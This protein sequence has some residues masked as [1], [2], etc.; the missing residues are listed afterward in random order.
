MYVVCVAQCRTVM[1]MRSFAVVAWNA[2]CRRG[3]VFSARLRGRW[4]LR[5]VHPAAIAFTLRIRNTNVAYCASQLRCLPSRANESFVT[6]LSCWLSRSLTGTLFQQIGRSTPI[7]FLL[8]LSAAIDIQN[9]YTA[10]SKWLKFWHDN[11][12]L[13]ELLFVYFK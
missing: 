2:C 10:F 5:T 4:L 7:L 1:V 9:V 6:P 13:Y 8:V 3:P 11:G 12:L